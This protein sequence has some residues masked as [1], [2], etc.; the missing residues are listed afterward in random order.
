MTAEE[1]TPV[2][3]RRYP[4]GEIIALFPTLPAEEYGYNVTSYVHVGQHGAAEYNYV[5]SNTRSTHP[6]DD[7][8]AMALFEEL[9][10]IGYRMLVYKRITNKHR[11]AFHAAQKALR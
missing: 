5:I 10:K 11:A 6:L 4:D 9:E 1:R 3:L 7:P 8:D 2:V